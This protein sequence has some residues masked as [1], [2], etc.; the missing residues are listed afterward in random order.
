MTAKEFKEWYT[1]I[2]HDL[3]EKQAGFP[4]LLISFPILERYIRQVSGIGENRLSDRFFEVLLEMFDELE[5][6][7][8]AKEFWQIYRNGLLHQVSFAMKNHKQIEMS[9]ACITFDQSESLLLSEGTYSVNPISFSREII[10]SVKDDFESMQ[11]SASP[12]HP[13]PY[14]FSRPEVNMTGTASDT[15]WMQNKNV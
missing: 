9:P 14:V 12:N 7:E 2:L 13:A 15:S 8:N 10:K 6:L 3:Y 11:A 1:D 5:C 4:I